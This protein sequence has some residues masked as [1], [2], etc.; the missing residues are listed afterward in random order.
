MTPIPRVPRQMPD[1]LTV[2]GAL[3]QLQPDSRAGTIH[4]RVE[5]RR[6]H[7]R[8]QQQR[9]LLFDMRVNKGERRQQ[10]RRAVYDPGRRRRPE[11]PSGI[12]V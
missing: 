10:R 2:A 4:D 7:D 1:P 9:P 12:Q 11:P 6:P 8:R 5:R 3:Q